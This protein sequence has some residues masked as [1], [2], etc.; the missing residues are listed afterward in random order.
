MDSFDETHTQLLIKTQCIPAFQKH[1][2]CYKN[3]CTIHFT[4]F[5]LLICCPVT[6]L[7]Y[8]KSQFYV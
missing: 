4:L 7:K 3:A 5:C 2:I 6:R 8:I 1:V